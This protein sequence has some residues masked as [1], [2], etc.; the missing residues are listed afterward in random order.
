MDGKDTV[1]SEYIDDF[2]AF[3]DECCQT[4]IIENKNLEEANIDLCDIE[5][6]V[7][8]E[9]ADGCTMTKIYKL[10]KETRC[11]RRRAKHNIELTVPIS[12][13]A[14]T[15]AKALRE[16]REV[17]GLVRKLERAQSIRAYAVKGNILD[18]I[19]NKSHFGIYEKN[20]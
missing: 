19:T 13:W 15:N 18:K 11:K 17:L 4:V 9:K 14:K 6:F 1:I 8:L 16:L 7:E 3:I 20:S 5:H 2:L 12:N 10:F